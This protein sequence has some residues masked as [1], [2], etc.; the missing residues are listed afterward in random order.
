MQ[1][2]STWNSR[3]RQRSN[4]GRGEVSRKKS[5][6][7]QEQ[8][9]PTSLEELCSGICQSILD[10]KHQPTDDIVSLDTILTSVPYQKILENLF[11]GAPTPQ[12][13]VPVITKAYEESFMRECVYQGERKCVM[14]NDCE[15]RFIDREN[16]FTGV[17]LRLP[18]PLPATPQMCVLCSR[19]HTQKMYYDMLYRPPAV[20]TG[21]IQRYGVLCS[22]QNEYSPDYALMMPPHGPVHCMPFPSPVHGRNN[23]TVQVRSAVRYVVQRTEAGFRPPSLKA[24]L[25]A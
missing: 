17:E 10:S 24:A 21:V 19:K 20:H 22:V 11:G 8:S 5:R 4:R 15:C 23:Y 9:E 12:C 14:G 2:P 16:P 13:N 25:D 7:V 18:G 1:V 3:K 6:W